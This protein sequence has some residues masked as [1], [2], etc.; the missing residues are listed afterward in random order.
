MRGTESFIERSAFHKKT[1]MNRQ[2]TSEVLR[3]RIAAY[4]RA[5]AGKSADR[6]T[7]WDYWTALSHAM[8]EL[9]AD[10]W[11]ETRDV[12][13]TVRQT[14]YFSAEFLVGRSMLN[15]LVNL[16]IYEEAKEAV[17]AYGINLTD[18]LEQENDPGLGNGGLG[19][20]AAC[21]LDSCATMNLPVTGYGILYRYGLFKQQITNGFQKEI[22]DSWMESGYP[23]VVRR[24]EERVK[25]H[26]NDIDVWAVPYD[27]PVTG[28]GTR[29]VNRLRLWK[30]EPAQE[31]DFNL[32][33]SQRFDDAVMERNRVND[34]WRVLYPNDTSYDGKVLRVRQQYFFVSASLNDIVRRYKAIHGEDLS[35]FAEY[36]S[37]QINDTHPAIGI[38]ELMRILVDENG[39]EWTKAWKIVHDTYAYTNHTVMQEALEKWDIGIFQYLFPRIYQ[40]IDGINLQF[41]NEA[42]ALKINQDMIDRMSPL[43]DGKV[44]MAFLAIYGS[45]SVNGVAALHTEILKKDTLKDWYRI[46][47]E[48]FSNK[49]NGVTPRRWLRTCNPELSGLITGLLGSEAWVTDLERLSDLS[50][51]AKDDAVM[52]RFLEI[53]KNS[54]QRLADYIYTKE[55]ITIDPDSVFDI[56]I[57]RLH[58]YKRQLLN[59]FYALNLYDR[60]KADPSLDLPPV[61]ILFGAK[62]APG[63]FRAKAII[64]LINEAARLINN[65]KDIKGRIKV[66]FVENY[67]VS[68]GERMFPAADISEQISTAGLEASGT[69]N[70]K[71]MMNGAVTLGT[72][73]GANVEIGESV[74]DENIYIFGCRVEDMDATRGFYNPRWQYENI[75]GLKKVIDRLVDG[76]LDDAGTG[77]FRDL[78]NALLQGSNW[79]PG[80]VFFVLGDFA[81][82]R[83]TRDRVYTDYTDRLNW[84]RKCWINICNSG[85]F[86]SDRTI[87]D[88]CDDIWKIRP[89][90][91]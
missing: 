89:V 11:E 31:F 49:T 42:A 69:G 41:R 84:A 82:Y 86:S 18:L 54:K 48:K 14:H 12:Y 39:V 85:R 52:E 62:A 9:M 81:D 4:V 63:Y 64:K 1:Y 87:Q 43:G 61:T 90:K 33:N 47:P 67:N 46:W 38:P 3:D 35:Q 44:R 36:N 58:E 23:F 78:Y 76:S 79:Q 25:V 21:F 34:I 71:F 10:D 32:F 17:A 2:I 70:M 57:K 5:D 29:N 74:G 40:I 72:C 73:D 19:R 27:M 20:L 80:D 77:M 51:Y 8:V 28:Y 7:L 22:P 83:T 15:N 88:Y 30:P 55:G 91:I 37:V 6:G 53:K 75:P 50:K 68:N 13:D 26:Y 16:G 60:I 24:E 45:R 65:D 56:Q 59:I 66:V